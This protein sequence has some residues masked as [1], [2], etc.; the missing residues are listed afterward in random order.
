[1]RMWEYKIVSLPALLN[2]DDEYDVEDRICRYG[3]AGWELVTVT[4]GLP[5]GNSPRS[6]AGELAFIFKRPLQPN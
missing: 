4:P 3:A 2:E 6:E 5:A 1:M